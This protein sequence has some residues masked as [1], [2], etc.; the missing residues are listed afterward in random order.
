MHGSLLSINYSWRPKIEL[1]GDLNGSVYDGL[2]CVAILFS[3]DSKRG[4][5][6]YKHSLIE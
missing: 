1:I 5:A 3:D 6:D 4:T 2:S